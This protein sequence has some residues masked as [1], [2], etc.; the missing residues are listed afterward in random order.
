MHKHFLSAT[1]TCSNTRAA[2]VPL[3]VNMPNITIIQSSHTSDLLLSALSPEARRAHI[4]PG[5]V[6]NS[7]IFVGKLCDSGCDVTFTQEKVEVNTH[8][9]SV[10]SGVRD[11]KSRLWR[12]ALQEIPQSNYKNAC[13]HAHETSNLKELINYLHAT[14][15]SLV[16][17]TWIK[18]IKNGNF[19]SWPGLTEYAAEKQKQ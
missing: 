13:H 19:S 14:A 6:H 17:S 16:K 2:H 8:G 1:A 9:K 18:A 3:H 11:Q 12:V 15:F 4:L 10:M 7:L 5:L